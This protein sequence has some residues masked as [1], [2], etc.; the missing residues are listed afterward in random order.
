MSQSQLI[1]RR[2]KSALIRSQDIKCVLA[3]SVRTW[4]I[5]FPRLEFCWSGFLVIKVL[6]TNENPRASGRWMNTGKTSHRASF[7]GSTLCLERKVA[8]LRNEPWQIMRPV[9]PTM[10]ARE[11]LRRK[12]EKNQIFKN[13]RYAV[14]KRLGRK[15]VL[16]ISQN[17]MM[18][19]VILQFLK[20]L[21]SADFKTVKEIQKRGPL[22]WWKLF[23]HK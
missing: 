5:C 12:K 20:Y 7:F 2:M 6:Q 10:P 23:W 15:A 13:P 1:N 4:L 18:E 16:D 17:T 14:Q 11:T 21:F 9:Q 19:V 22:F 3:T 8:K